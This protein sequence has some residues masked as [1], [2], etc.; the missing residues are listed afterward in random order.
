MNSFFWPTYNYAIKHYF[1]VSQF[2]MTQK[3]ILPKSIVKFI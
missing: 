2:H 1:Y 3:P